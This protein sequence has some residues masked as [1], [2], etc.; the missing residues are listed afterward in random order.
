[1]V[2]TLLVLAT[3]GIQ[4]AFAP[5]LVTDFEEVIPEFN[6]RRIPAECTKAIDTLT[7]MFLLFGNNSMELSELSDTSNIAKNMMVINSMKWSCS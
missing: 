6:P 2:K 5:I 1:M 4:L 3:L 7:H